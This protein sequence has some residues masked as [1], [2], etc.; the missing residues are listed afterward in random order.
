MHVL[1]DFSLNVKDAIITLMFLE[2]C[3]H[4]SWILKYGVFLVSCWENKHNE[5]CKAFKITSFEMSNDLT[6]D[7][8]AF[9]AL[10]V[11]L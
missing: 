11:L 2:I 5:K 3:L 1:S 9:E 6:C 7:I 8:K 4:Y 10:G